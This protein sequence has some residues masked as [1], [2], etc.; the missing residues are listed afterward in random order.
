MAELLD[1]V[2]RAALGKRRRR[3]RV[4]L[5]GEQQGS[6]FLMALGYVGFLLNL[7]NLSPIGFLDGGSIWRSIKTMRLGGTPGKANARDRR[8]TSGSPRCSWSA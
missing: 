5:V 1:L 6:R 4:W 8:S 3:A 7:F 2:L